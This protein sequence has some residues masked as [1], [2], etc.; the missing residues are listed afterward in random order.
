MISDPAPANVTLVKDSTKA[1]DPQWE[2][3]TSQGKP[4]STSSSSNAPAKPVRRVSL[5]SLSIKRDHSGAAKQ[6]LQ[7]SDIS[8][9]VTSK[10][11][12]SQPA[13][14]T[15]V[16]S[17]TKKPVSIVADKVVSDSSVS[18]PNAVS[19]IGS[20]AGVSK[21]VGCTAI[22]SQGSGSGV[23]HVA[24]VVNQV[25][26]EAA[27]STPSS[28]PSATSNAPDNVEV[29]ILSDDTINTPS[30]PFM[31]EDDTAATSSSNSDL[32]KSNK[33]ML[34]PEKNMSK[35]LE[36]YGDSVS[37]APPVH[38]KQEQEEAFKATTDSSQL[39]TN[40]DKTV[41]ASGV[42]KASSLSPGEKAPR[43]VA[44]LTL[45]KA[46]PPQK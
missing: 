39:E 44:F 27:Y 2:P 31:S 5:V 38:S 25:A 12:L 15:A 3:L 14:T 10:S 18:E 23:G 19:K 37:E 22:K 30:K 29:I 40:N 33:A 46:G 35:L 41:S 24:N 34:N 11:A 4:L 43:R 45:G 42:T 28:M 36:K 32:S 6:N 8:S 16:V 9:S 20:Y 7:K 1:Q 13:L 17:S 21:S 26:K